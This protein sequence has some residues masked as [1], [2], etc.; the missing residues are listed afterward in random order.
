MARTRYYKGAQPNLQGPHFNQP[1]QLY[2]PGSEHTAELHTASDY[3]SGIHYTSRNRVAGRW[4]EVIL[5]VEVLGEQFKISE[6][7]RPRFR[8]DIPGDLAM[9]KYNKYR[10]D[11]L[12]VLGI[13]GIAA[14]SWDGRRGSEQAAHRI[15]ALLDQTLTRNGLLPTVWTGQVLERLRD[16]GFLIWQVIDPN[17]VP[18]LGAPKRRIEYVTITDGSGRT[19]TTPMSNLPAPIIAELTRR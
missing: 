17:A 14:Y 8:H 16:D 15:E 3:G 10:T 2:L 4:A 5:E 11:R 7:V 13:V 1:G 19:M 12:R 6:Q 9:G 18:A